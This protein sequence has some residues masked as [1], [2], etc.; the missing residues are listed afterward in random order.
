MGNT[1]DCA[2]GSDICFGAAAATAYLSSAKS[3]CC[4]CEI[5]RRS[6]ESTTGAAPFVLGL[7]RTASSS[8]VEELRSGVEKQRV[9]LL[10]RAFVVHVSRRGKGNDDIA[11]G[12]KDGRKAS[13]DIIISEIKATAKTKQSDM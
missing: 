9:V 6:V 1:F 5:N 10:L 2:V 11:T 13:V 12:E 8:V 3:I 4:C 7:V